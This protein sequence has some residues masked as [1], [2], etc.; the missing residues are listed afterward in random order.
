MRKIPFKTGEYYHV[1]NRGAD[2]R[3]VFS[4]V[5]DFSRFFRS[6]DE[7]NTPKP[8]GSIF[9][10]SFRKK[11]P[12]GHPMS[13]LVEFICYCVNPNH[14]HFVLKQVAD[15]GIEKFMQKLGNGYTKYF[16]NKHKRS[17]VLFQGKFKAIHIS[18]NEYL[19]HVSAYV[20]LN[21]KVHKIALGHPMSKSSWAE[22]QRKNDENFCLAKKEILGQF[23]NRS[24]YVKFAEDTVRGIIEKRNSSK[25]MEE[26]L[27]D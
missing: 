24:D 2:K 13:K 26:L 18:S 19:L 16:N 1:Y 7:F 8:I 5:D 10:N 21:N 15:S 12:L 27:L 6:M 17:G 20:N 22:Y 11:S 23:K 9:E 4:D 3:E 25:E 14:Y